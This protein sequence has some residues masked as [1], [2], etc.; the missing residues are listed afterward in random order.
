MDD[1]HL[2]SSHSAL[3]PL[4]DLFLFCSICIK[5]TFC[6][7]GSCKIL[8][9]NLKSTSK[10]H[11][12]LLVKALQSTRTSSHLLLNYNMINFLGY[13]IL[14]SLSSIQESTLRLWATKTPIVV[15]QYP[16]TESL[17]S[18]MASILHISLARESR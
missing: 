11:L 9:F 14:P 7:L 8:Q 2:N 18:L 1:G 3:I 12:D 15:S 10:S 5:T 17:E 16:T 6:E 13:R 4:K